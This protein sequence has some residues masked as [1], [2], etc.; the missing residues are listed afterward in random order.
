MELAAA[1]TSPTEIW[2]GPANT[3]VP[4]VAA[5]CGP[6][7]VFTGASLTATPVIDLVP[8]TAGATPSL[9]LVAIVKLPLKS[10]VGVQVSP[11]SNALTFATGPLAVHTPVP[12]TYVDVTEP[13]VPVFKLPAAGLDNVSVTVTVGLSTSL[14]TISVRFSAVSSVY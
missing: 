7:M 3:S 9:T 5:F 12:T 13:D 14:T 8:V 4:F 11:A 6:G 2:L 1:S 10:W